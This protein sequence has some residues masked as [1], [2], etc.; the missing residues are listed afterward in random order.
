MRGE[1]T[2]EA[3]RIAALDEKTQLDEL[4]ATG[5]VMPHWPK[6]WGRA[7][8]AV[9]QLLVE[10][11]FAAAGVKRP[12][13]GITGWVILT[14]IQHGTPSQIERFVEKALRKDEIWCQLFSEP[15]AGSDAAAVKTRAT[16]VYGGW[17]ISGQKVW[18]SGAHYAR[19]GLA[20]VRTDFEVPKHAGITM[21]IIDM[22]APGVEVR[23]LRQITGGSEFN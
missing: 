3:Q 17:R 6:P 21:V 1:I 23:P 4:I 20:T 19:R 18:T 15:S 16:R 7:A 14:L 12:D 8:G 11:E 10:E 5:Y 13:Y 2:A 9:E 22:K